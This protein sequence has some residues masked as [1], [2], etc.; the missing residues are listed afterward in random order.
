MVDAM[1][2]RMCNLPWY[3]QIQDVIIFHSLRGIK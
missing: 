2:T 1:V 3:Q